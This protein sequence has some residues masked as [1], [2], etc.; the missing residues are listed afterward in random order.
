MT[1]YEEFI[2]SR[3]DVCNGLPIIKGTRIR[4]KVV[5]DN[6]AEGHTPEEIVRAYPGLTIDA[7]FAAIAY[8]QESHGQYP[9]TLLGKLALSAMADDDLPRDFAE[10]HDHYLYGTPKHQGFGSPV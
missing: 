1:R 10:H 8:H 2:V 3:P 5:L 9:K 6:L 7:V 4:L